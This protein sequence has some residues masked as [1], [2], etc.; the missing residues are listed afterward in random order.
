MNIKPL[1]SLT[2]E[3]LIELIKH[4]RTDHCEDVLTMVP[5]FAEIYVGNGR[6]AICDWEDFDLVKGFKWNLTSRNKSGCIYA[7]A[8]DYG[9]PKTRNKQIMHRM[10]MGV[11]GNQIIDHIN[12]NG[13]DNRRNN[14]RIVTTQQNAFNQKQRGGSSRFKGVCFDKESGK[15]RAYIRHK[16]RRVSLGRHLYEIDAAKAYDV[17]AKEFFCEYAKLNFG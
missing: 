12:G 14:L 4:E 2:K 5:E 7:Q 6:F 10:I 11:D 9:N 17:A 13:L 1:E 3:E 8:W 15:W 16:N